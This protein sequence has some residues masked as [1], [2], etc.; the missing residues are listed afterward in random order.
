MA[1][2]LLTSNPV[3][4]VSPAQA[5]T[6]A[7][8]IPILSFFTGLGLMDLGFHN[9]GF[10]SV[11][12][13]EYAKDFIKGFQYGMES[14]GVTGS[15]AQIQDSSSIVDIG[16]NQILRQAFGSGGRPSMFGMIGGPPCPDFSVGGKNR[17]SHGDRGKLSEVYVN[18]ILEIQPQFF[19]FENVPGLLR[20]AKH[21]QFLGHLM[22]KLSQSYT[23]DLRV[24][25]ALDY[26]VPQDRERVIMVG[27]RRSW[28]KRNGR[29]GNR[30]Q[31]PATL[32]ENARGSADPAVPTCTDSIHWMPWDKYRIYPDAKNKFRWPGMSPFR[33]V[34]ERPVGCPAALMVGPL[35]CDA[36]EIERL[37]NGTEGFL[38]YSSR[39]Q[40]VQEGDDSKKCFKRLHR[41]RYSPAAAYGNNEV[42]LHPT[43]P[44]RLTV[45]EAMRIQTVPDAFALPTDMTLT[46]KFK[47]IGNAVP[48]ELAKSIA[49]SLTDVVDAI[50]KGHDYANV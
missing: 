10:Q 23:L 34:P 47:T 1:N 29:N 8:R 38:P 50:L 36:R 35:I 16:P 28:L 7:H 40:T 25:N 12:H 33:G 43:E 13:N 48:V 21:R 19:V 42:H 31:I 5:I 45:R 4:F 37:P 22:Q 24:V 49:L 41:W 11:W 18:R 14:I 20:T 2:A 9:A 32:I 46:S 6:T 17:G 39:F 30:K 27:L 15:G 3:K 44:R 26:G